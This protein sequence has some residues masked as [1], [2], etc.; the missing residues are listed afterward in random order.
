MHTRHR[1]QAQAEA[2]HPHRDPRDIEL[3]SRLQLALTDALDQN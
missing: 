1:A 3:I 2:P